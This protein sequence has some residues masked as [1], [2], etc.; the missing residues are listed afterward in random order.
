MLENYNFNKNLSNHYNCERFMTDI[1]YR[2]AFFFWLKFCQLTKN[3][4]E[5]LLNRVF[6]LF[7]FQW[8]GYVQAKTPVAIQQRLVVY[9]SEFD[10]R[11]QGR[12]DVQ[13][14]SENILDQLVTSLLISLVILPSFPSMIPCIQKSNALLYTTV[15]CRRLASFHTSIIT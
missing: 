1:T 2:S 14:G 15:A 9:K 12:I 11:T 13:I 8:P 5:I 4:E 7:L 6:L 3:S 10:P